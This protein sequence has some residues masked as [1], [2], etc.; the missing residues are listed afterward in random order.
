MWPVMRKED[1]R[2]DSSTTKGG[3]WIVGWNPHGLSVIVTGFI[4]EQSM[5]NAMTKL[6]ETRKVLE[7]YRAHNGMPQYGNLQILG[8]VRPFINHNQ[9]RN[10]MTG[11]NVANTGLSPIMNA[12]SN[13]H[14]NIARLTQRRN[15]LW[16]ELLEGPILGEIWCCGYRVQPCQLHI[17]RCDPFKRYSLKPTVFSACALYGPSGVRRLLCG[18]RPVC[19]PNMQCNMEGV[20][21]PEVMMG[22]SAPNVENRV[23]SH[24][25]EPMP[26]WYNLAFAL[27]PLEDLS[28]C[29]LS[30]MRHW[31]PQR[32]LE[33]ATGR[34]TCGELNSEDGENKR[35]SASRQTHYDND[36]AYNGSISDGS[37][38]EPLVGVPPR[39]DFP[40]SVD[41]SEIVV[42]LSMCCLG[43]NVQRVLLGKDPVRVVHEPID[44]SGL[45][46]RGCGVALDVESPKPSQFLRLIGVMKRVALIGIPVSPIKR[47]NATPIGGKV[48]FTQASPNASI[49]YLWPYVHHLLEFLMYGTLIMLR[50]FK[51]FSRFSWFVKVMELRLREFVNFVSL[52]DGQTTSCGLHP[53]LPHQ[54]ARNG[55]QQHICFLNYLGRYLTDLVLGISIAFLVIY[56]SNT[57]FMMQH[58]SR[59]FLFNLH[60]SYMDWFEGWPAGLKM[61]EDFNASLGFFAKMVLTTWDRF[62]CFTSVSEPSMEGEKTYAWITYVYVLML[63]ISPMGA[64]TA[65][66]ILA[67]VIGIVTLHLHF[68]YQSMALV[69]RF[70]KE[71]FVSLF[72]QFRGK[73]YNKLRNRTDAYEFSVEQMLI[74]TFLF[75]ITFFLFPTVAVYYL[76]FA[77]VRT[78]IWFI[79][80]GLIGVSHLLLYMPFFQISHWALFRR[81]YIGGMVLSDPI[82][83]MTL[84]NSA[85]PVASIPKI[86][87]DMNNS[88][89]NDIPYE[90]PS[91]TVELS[92]ESIPLSLSSVLADFLVVLS[93]L[94][95][96]FMPTRVLSLL[97]K[98]EVYGW[99]ESP[100]YDLIPHLLENC[101]DPHCTL[102]RDEKKDDVDAVKTL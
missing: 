57:H 99:L 65:L 52:L 50:W 40:T 11:V 12:F 90:K 14:E 83:T 96:L 97:R 74:A 71:L 85:S 9:G 84:K 94:G 39:L 45:N 88:N 68:L 98:G 20:L 36:R 4:R 47:Y 53:V 101:V 37:A 92:I 34:P 46:A 62:L 19:L 23:R 5:E 8:Y 58:I 41:F 43:G 32:G 72:N 16:L 66:A 100:I 38:A 49:T 76:Y 13:Q 44:I 59:Y 35:M 2:L 7:V 24:A 63:Y 26:N 60:M 79:Q 28:Q 81:Q 30:G 78:S 73:K 15:D 54:V 48:E 3:S 22:E 6:E 64:S 25:M 21:L 102:L 61:N 18:Q 93:V 67:D 29:S 69:Y 75:T 1:G 10:G 17:I 70:A 87:N 56:I 33:S 42:A 55:N 77:F 80:E 82:I 31:T 89:F 27:T 86:G 91:T 95:K 51:P